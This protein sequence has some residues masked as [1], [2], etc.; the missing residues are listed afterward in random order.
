M[1][2][3][4]LIQKQK[5]ERVEV[6]QKTGLFLA[7]A[8]SIITSKRFQSWFLKPDSRF[9]WAGEPLFEKLE[10]DLMFQVNQALL[11]RSDKDLKSIDRLQLIAERCDNLVVWI[12][13][14]FTEISFAKKD[15]HFTVPKGEVFSENLYEYLSRTYHSGLVKDTTG[16]F[17][18]WNALEALILY[19]RARDTLSTPLNNPVFEK[20]L[21]GMTESYLIAGYP[22][23]VLANDATAIRNGEPIKALLLRNGYCSTWIIK[24]KDD[25]PQVADSRI[26]HFKSAARKAA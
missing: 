2:P 19:V 11:S 14:T 13:E 25:I 15:K 24:T 9:D 10:K 23:D 16:D 12:E 21:S 5:E 26:V 3:M 8:S 18:L 22:H 20:V 17:Y 4:S 1:Y 6:L 7:K